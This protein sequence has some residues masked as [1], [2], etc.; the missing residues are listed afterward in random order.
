MK[1]EYSFYAE[2]PSLVIK[3]SDFLKALDDKEEFLLLEVAIDG[4]AS[5]YDVTSHFDDAVNEVIKQW[6]TKTGEV[7]YTTKERWVGNRLSNIWC[8]VYVRNGSRITE[9]V[10]SDTGRDFAL[11]NKEEDTNE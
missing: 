6:L 8:E 9:I 5:H 2:N 3:G 7:I 1:V 4:F 11:N 10:V